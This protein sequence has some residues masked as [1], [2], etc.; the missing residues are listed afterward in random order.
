MVAH[1]HNHEHGHGHHHGTSNKKALLFSFL[2]I[3]FFMIVEAVGG[4]LTNSLALLSDAGHMLSDAAALGLSLLAFKI[5]ERQA[6]A[7][8]T[9]GYR[10][11]EIIAAFIN[12]VTLI[13][14]SLY[15]FYE[16]FQRFMEPP[17]VS[18]SMMIIAII[19]LIVNI[20]AAWVLM[21]GDSQDNLNIRSALL[22]VF[23]D[24]L[25][26]IGAIIAGILILLFDWN[27]ADP[28]A[29]VIVAFLIILS[30][31]RITKDSIHIL[32]EGKPANI[33]VEE[34]KQKLMDL[35]G[36]HNVHDLHVWSITS[37]F[38]AL[39]C[40]LVVDDTV[41]RDTLLTQANQQLKRNFSIS[42]CTLQI[43]GKNAEIQEDCEDCSF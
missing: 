21:R 10:R 18:A 16:A 24:L 31:I 29:S 2:L 4:F 26:S 33:D 1:G 25:G 20:I 15:I 7:S 6:T 23:G 28:I 43:E 32:M 17:N 30:G 14:I 27:I 3:T 41:D 22:H 34:V 12:G 9:Y 5:G 13:V 8:K 36:V 42:H 38:P 11:F 35:K 37:E 39:S 40:H 19:G